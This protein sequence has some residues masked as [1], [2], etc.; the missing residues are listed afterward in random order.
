MKSYFSSSDDIQD[1]LNRASNNSVLDFGVTIVNTPLV[2]SGKTN[3]TLKGTLIG[4]IPTHEWT[5]I[6]PSDPLYSRFPA[7][8]RDNIWTT[9]APMPGPNPFGTVGAIQ[10]GNAFVRNVS[11]FPTLIWDGEAMTL[12]R[13]PDYETGGVAGS[14]TTLIYQGTRPDGYA[15]VSGLAVVGYFSYSWAPEMRSVSGINTGTKTLTCSSSTYG[16]VLANTRF[17]YTNVPEELDS[18]GEYFIDRLHLGVYGRVYFIPPGLV[19]PNTKPSYITKVNSA[20]LLTV[21]SCNELISEANLIGSTHGGLWVSSSNDILVQ[22][23]KVSGMGSTAINLSGNNVSVDNVNV[24]STQ[25]IGLYIASGNR[26]NFSPISTTSV[27]NCDFN[28]NSILGIHD[29]SALVLS[30]AGFDVNNC[31]FNESTGSSIR[32]FGNDVLIDNCTFTNVLK[33]TRDSGVIY[34][35]RNPS[36]A[37]IEIKN[38]VLNYNNLLTPYNNALT[39]S[40]NDAARAGFFAAGIYADDGSGSA[41]I[42]NCTFNSDDRGIYMNGGRNVNVVNPIFNNCHQPWYYFGALTTPDVFGYSL[43]SLVGKA[44]TLKRVVCNAA[45]TPTGSPQSM[46]VLPLAENIASGSPI[47]F[48]HSYTGLK[49]AAAALAGATSIS[50]V[51][52][53]STGLAV[54]AGTTVTCTSLFNSTSTPANMSV[55]ALP[56]N[57][58]AGQHIYFPGNKYVVVATIAFAGATTISVRSGPSYLPVNQSISASAVGTTVDIGTSG[59]E[60]DVVCNGNFTSSSSTAS[61][62]VLALKRSLI[63][64]TDI[65]FPSE[66]RFVVLQSDAAEGATSISVRAGVDGGGLINLNSVG[67]S[68]GYWQMTSMLHGSQIDETTYLTKYPLLDV[69][70]NGATDAYRLPNDSSI[71]NATYNSCKNP[72]VKLESFYGVTFD[73]S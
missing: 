57:I 71:T 72:A 31:T 38:C 44:S 11:K 27:T 39:L 22:D 49:A 73:E 8:T 34:W 32:F 70:F 1:M 46:S 28:N 2:L 10:W 42:E 56:S 19:D 9:T 33:A 53:F 21:S 60:T 63:A 25:D 37:G 24:T 62:S 54:L 12:A 40:Q 7:G 15:S 47:F 5:P 13:S 43:G 36:Y 4:G 41:Y 66:D 14:T 26:Y 52:Y 67:K 65:Y 29:T 23:C 58:P 3:I 51:N 50:V 30:G 17:F 16:A 45:I 68:G 48:G 61:M 64:Q 69:Y 59:T 6:S 20:P 35:G 18:P 55:S